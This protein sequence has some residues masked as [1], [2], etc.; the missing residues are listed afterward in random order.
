MRLAP[1]K[2]WWFRP[3]MRYRSNDDNTFLLNSWTLHSCYHFLHLIDTSWL[4]EVHPL[5]I[6]PKRFI[7]HFDW[8]YILT[9]DHIWDLCFHQKNLFHTI[10]CG[11]Q[12]EENDRHLKAYIVTPVSGIQD[13]VIHIHLSEFQ[14]DHHFQCGLG[15]EPFSPLFPDIKMVLLVLWRTKYFSA[16]G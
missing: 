4:C 16:K 5:L 10:R 13:L 1:P 9:L 3:R 12:N 11:F 7:V 14:T 2:M 6:L 8:L 15:F